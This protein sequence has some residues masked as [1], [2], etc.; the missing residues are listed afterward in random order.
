MTSTLTH[1]RYRQ[2]ACVRTFGDLEWA[3]MG[4]A[5]TARHPL[6]PAEVRERLQRERSL[7]YTTVLTVMTRLHDKGWLARKK[8]GRAY[9]YW[10]T[11]SR[12]EYAAELMSEA[13]AISGDE[14]AALTLL[15]ERLGA[16]VPGKPVDG[17]RRDLLQ[18]AGLL[19]Q[20]RRAGDHR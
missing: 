1:P 14:T 19:E 8:I 15:A 5:W 2:S 4:L 11:I 12:T 6:R 18:R 16:E 3:I 9:C 20:M 7:A 13:L 17:Q 10:P